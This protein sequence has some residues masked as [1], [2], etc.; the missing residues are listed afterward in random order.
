LHLLYVGLLGERIRLAA[1][2]GVTFTIM[3]ETFGG[4]G[5]LLFLI[6]GFALTLEQSTQENKTA[7]NHLYTVSMI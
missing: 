4:V 5:R 7:I 3:Y 6:L 2:A 1:L